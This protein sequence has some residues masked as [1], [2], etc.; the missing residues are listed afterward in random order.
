MK[1]LTAS[2]WFALVDLVCA[3]ASGAIWFGW[4]QGLF[5][6]SL[7]GPAPYADESFW[8]YLWRAGWPLLV[9]MIPWLMR[10]GTGRFPF[11]RTRF[12]LFLI[13]FLAAAAAGIWAAYDRQAAWSKFWV[14]L[15]GV[16]LFYA[17]AGQPESNL[18]LVAGLLGLFGAVLATAFLLWQDFHK[19]YIDLAILQP[20]VSAWTSLRPPIPPA[21]LPPNIM[22]G[23][24]ALLAPFSIAS[25]LAACRHRWLPGVLASLAAAVLT[26]FALVLTS[27]RGAWIALLL[28]LV[29]WGL[30]SGASRFGRFSTFLGA[31][32]RP[33]RGIPA[34]AFIFAAVLPA[35]LLIGLFL[36]NT[37]FL[38]DLA[39]RI[40]G[41]PSG[42]SRLNLWRD[43][44]LLLADFP[45]TGGGL[46]AFGGL[47]SQYIRVIPFFFFGYSHNLFL[48]VAIE[49]GAFGLL[50]FCVIFLGS[51]YLVVRAFEWAPEKSFNLLFG[52]L[53]AGLLVI[54][55]HGLVDDALYSGLGTPGVF[56]LPGLAVA[57]SEVRD[58]S[59]VNKR[60]DQERQGTNRLII[61]DRQSKSQINGSRDWLLAGAALLLAA[62]LAAI[63][64]RP[65][66][67]E[68]YAN[69][70][71]V[72]MARAELAGFPLGNWD[73]VR[74]RQVLDSREVQSAASS[75][76]RSLALNPGNA[77]SRYRLGLISLGRGDFSSAILHLE[78]VHHTRPGH[79]GVVK[80]LGYSYVW[81]GKME[82][83]L[84]LLE[85]I[86]EAKS[87]MDVYSWWWKERGRVD[88]ANQSAQMAVL[89]ANA[90]HSIK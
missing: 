74:T 76:D 33:S 73:E 49:Q 72:E 27:S 25:G 58:N 63:W 32:G 16:F 64:W 42:V 29:L 14:L 41:S 30:W 50:A 3:L 75:F 85:Q 67:S 57:L 21:E 43:S 87:E 7:G 17:L 11:K 53:L 12:D 52:G 90:G 47:Y 69:Q 40:P 66:V 88:L 31:A 55:V 78:A 46:A 44:L 89:L 79:R 36:S 45:Y 81:V 71:A 70:G 35:I 59:F 68:W 86:P 65:L 18:W 51:I 2:R 15:G 23:W 4:S 6:A 83:A 84:P 39:D 1:A 48:D 38:V 54:G 20:V 82:L 24:L 26:G 22:G 13:I 62:G 60:T 5:R 56:L 34:P 77:T 28:A 10:I 19:Q 61:G 8:V 80:V 9:A 37:G